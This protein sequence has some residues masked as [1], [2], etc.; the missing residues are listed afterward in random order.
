M[1]IS[2]MFKEIQ[3]ILLASYTP[4]GAALWWE[5]KRF[6]LNNRTPYEAWYDHDHQQ[7]FKLAQS[8]EASNFT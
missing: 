4:E 8:L 1:N 5:R 6:E 2:E 3:K 7:V